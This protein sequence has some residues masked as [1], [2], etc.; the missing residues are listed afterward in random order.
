MAP[1]KPLLVIPRSLYKH[2]S[3]P[4]PLTCKSE[5]AAEL[6]RPRAGHRTTLAWPL[7]ETDSG[8]NQ[9]S[10]L[11]SQIL[12]SF[13]FLPGCPRVWYSVRITFVSYQFSSQHL[14]A[15]KFTLGP[16]AG[17]LCAFF[18]PSLGVYVIYVCA[19]VCSGGLPH[20]C[21]RGGERATLGS[22][23]IAPSMF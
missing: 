17:S 6:T 10:S 7:E 3:Q 8:S 4:H 2:S 14:Q 20:A 16:I 23:H 11:V 9:I 1:L 18:I 21:M 19:H 13:P 22:S 12:S 5:Q 15:P